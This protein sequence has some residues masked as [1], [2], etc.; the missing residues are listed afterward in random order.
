[1][2]CSRISAFVRRAR[3]GDEGEGMAR[4]GAG[5]VAEGSADGEASSSAE[6]AA[7]FLTYAIN[8]AEGNEG[9]T[10]YLEAT[11]S[12]ELGR[13]SISDYYY[14]PVRAVFARSASS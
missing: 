8:A 10:S 2:V 6:T 12:D 14:T 7:N 5:S 1:M 3:G 13:P 4:G 11:M 9:A